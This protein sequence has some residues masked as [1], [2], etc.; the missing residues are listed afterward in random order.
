MC[1]IF[2]ILCFSAEKMNIPFLYIFFYLHSPNTVLYSHC[3]IAH[4]NRPIQM[5]LLSVAIALLYMIAYL[6]DGYI[7]SSSKITATEKKMCRQLE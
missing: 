2:I 1:I 4:M 3:I 5:P 7:E 6:S